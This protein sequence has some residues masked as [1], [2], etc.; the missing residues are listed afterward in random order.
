[1]NKYDEIVIDELDFFSPDSVQID[2]VNIVF[3]LQIL[4]EYFELNIF[5]VFGFKLHIITM[6]VLDN[7][8]LSA[9]LDDYV[10]ASVVDEIV[11]AS[12][13]DLLAAIIDLQVYIRVDILLLET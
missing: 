2:V 11:F 12:K 3:I 10:I 6:S 1:M 9:L 13:I 4:G 5:V 7:L 8:L